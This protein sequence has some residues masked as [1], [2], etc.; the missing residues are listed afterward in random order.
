MRVS[1]HLVDARR[2]RLASLIQQRGYMPIAQVCR[3]FQI[4]EPTVR[5]DLAALAG[6]R[7]IKRTF[8]GALSDFNNRFPSFRQRRS[9]NATGK[10]RIALAARSLIEPG[11][12]CYLDAGTTIYAL[13]EA[14]VEYPVSPLTLVTPSLPVSDL[15][16]NI[17][18]VRLHLPGGEIL[19]RQSVLM[20]SAS[21][22]EL[23]HWKFD[24]AFICAEAA[25]ARGLWNTQDSIV[26]QQLAAARHARRIIVCL[27]SLKVG[28][29]ASYHLLSWSKD[30]E[31]VTEAGSARL[32]RLKL[33]QSVHVIHA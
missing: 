33:P 3:E 26:R 29:S 24:V 19:P 28:R 23:G 11:W 6:K 32:G 21:E 2:R 20:G 16:C 18:G 27:D 15:L 30:L 4:S 8:G 25:N 1:R 7:Q 5:R 22:R 17:E 14:L 31:L 9:R 12:T 13:A 10:R